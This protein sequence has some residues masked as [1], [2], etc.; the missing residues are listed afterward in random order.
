MA[1]P[2][3]LFET[4][5]PAED[6]DPAYVHIR[7]HHACAEDRAYLDEAWH[8]FRAIADPHFHDQTQRKGSFQARMWE[9]RLAWTLRNL[10]Y[11]VFAKRPAGPDMSIY[12]GSTTVHIEAVAP[13]PSEALIVNAQQA[14][15]TC[16][17]VPEEA[18]ILRATSVMSAKVES[19]RRYVE[20]GIVA[21]DEPYVLAISGANIPQADMSDEVPWILKPLYGI[22][23][24]YMAI[25]IVGDDEPE[26][27]WQC[28]PIRKTQK[29]APVNSGIFM[30]SGTSELSAILFSPNHIKNRPEYSSRPPG[31]DIILAHNPFARNPL[32]LG[33]IPRGVEYGPRDGMIRLLSDWRQLVPTDDDAV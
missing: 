26:F 12:V 20:T 22:G 30:D 2:N 17:T 3:S 11:D 18:M 24:M 10:G 25:D 27:G 16:A 5:V 14:L 7:D 32:P 29:G 23:E 6:L 8:F 4:T 31:D 28:I 13:Q 19:Y 15:V 9:L 1:T 21:P 33:L